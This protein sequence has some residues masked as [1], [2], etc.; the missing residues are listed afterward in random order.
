MNNVGTKFIMGDVIARLHEIHQCD[1]QQCTRGENREITHL[2]EKN[3]IIR[4][5]I[6]STWEH[7]FYTGTHQNTKFNGAEF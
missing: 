1:K 4:G 5:G 3:E 7:N 2:V 6:G